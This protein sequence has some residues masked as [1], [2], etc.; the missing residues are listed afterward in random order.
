MKPI[1]VMAGTPVDTQMGVDCLASHGLNGL[2]YPV[3]EDPNQQ[4]AFQISSM[5]E[6]T[7]V[8]TEILKTAQ[9]EHDCE[10]AFIYCNSL[11]GS[12]DFGPIARETGLKIVT[13]LDVYRRWAAH[14]RSLAVIAANAQGAAGIERTLLTANPVLTLHSTGLLPVVLSIE[15]GEAPAELVTH[16]HLPELCDWYQQA[17]AEA[18]VLGCTHFP[19]FKEALASRISLP[20]L[21]PAE[22]MLKLLCDDETG[23]LC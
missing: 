21:D 23:T 16:H 18:L 7:R 20:I 15:A 19:Y 2:F 14:Y 12:V 8:V 9:R 4:T 1:I 17:G 22:E 13:P 6:K 11:S 3:S 10:K 5:E